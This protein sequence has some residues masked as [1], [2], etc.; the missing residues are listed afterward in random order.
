MSTSN[1]VIVIGAGVIGCAIASDLTRRGARVTVVDGRGVAGGA[2]Q[3]SAGILSPYIEGHGS[4]GLLE[5]GV[6][7][8]GMY[9]E[10]VRTVVSESGVAVPYGRIGTLEVATAEDGV[11]ALQAAA[12]R[13]RA[14][15]LRAHLLDPAG[16]KAAEPLLGDGVAAG[17]LVEEHAYVAPGALSEAL[18]AAASRRGA[19]FVKSDVRTIAPDGSNVRVDLGDRTLHAQTVV[20]AAGSWSGNL[21]VDG[22]PGLPVRPVRGQ[23]LYLSWSGPALGHITWGARCYLVP[24]PDGTVLLGATVEDAG[25]DERA[26]VAGVRDLLD[27]ACELVPQ[28][29][30]SGFRSAR[31]GLRPASPDD[32]P[33][34]GRSEKVPGLV[35][36]TGHFRN[37]ILLAPLTGHVVASLIAEGADDPS[38][39]LMSPA[40]FGRF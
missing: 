3:A 33:I 7:S 15:G 34:V 26:T 24:W 11:A 10:F 19:S 17:L 16:A 1:D 13:H 40:R 32:M 35:Y 18:S 5:L 30:Q 36:A 21:G 29:W 38:L 28:T 20:L 23:L 31:V 25:F 14:R 4:A 12:A 6:R 9:D 39:R 37:G 27:A 2:T 8:L 22:L